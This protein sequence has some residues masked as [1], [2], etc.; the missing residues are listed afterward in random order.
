MSVDVPTERTARRRV[1]VVGNGGRESALRWAC[2]QFGHDVLPAGTDPFVA[3]PDL[4]I[5]GPEAPLADGLVD[6]LAAAGIPAFG[7]TAACARLEASKAYAREVMTALGLEGPRWHQVAQ[8]DVDGALAWFRASGFPIVVKLSGLA[9]GKGVIVPTDEVTTEAAIRG[10]VAQGDVVLEER[11][12]GPECSLLAFCDGTTARPMPIAQDHKRIGEGDTGPNTGGMGA[13]APAPLPY[14]ADL[15]T[16]QFIQP[17]LDHMRAAGTP[18]VGVLYAGLML[19]TDGPRLLEYNCRFGDPET[20]AILPLLHT[21]VVE[22]AE[23]CIAGRLAEID[24]RWSSGTACT[25]V[26]AAAGYPVDPRLGDEVFIG[27][28]D[29]ATVFLAGVSEIDGAA[30][31][32]GG[33]V[34][35]VTGTGSDLASARS[36]AYAGMAA[37]RFDGMQ[38]RRDIGWRAIASSLTTYAAAGVDIDE[39]NR[40]VSLLKESVKHTHNPSVLAGV[41]SFGGAIDISALKHYDRPVLVASTDGVGT[42]VELA[43]RAGRPEVSGMDIVNHCIDDVLVQG[44]RPLFFLDYIAAA[45]LDAELVA[46]VVDGMATACEASGCVLLG[47]ETAEM[48][49]VYTAGSFDVAGTLVGVVDHAQM[50]PRPGAVQPGDMLIGLGSSGPHT[51]GYSF[52]RKLFQWLPLDAQPAPLDRPLVD[53]LLQPHR[54]YITALDAALTDGRIKALAHITGGGLPENLPR[55]LPDGCGAV[56]QLDSWTLPP[57]FQLVRDVAWQTPTDELYRTLNM[58][59]GMVLIV[60][61][62]DVDRVRDSIPEQTWVIGEIVAGSGCSLV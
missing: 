21:D 34:L 15:L 57:L 40:A 59:I 42:K 9:A 35:S 14:D 47:G 48:P 24:I 17:I 8:G 13:Y 32:S 46:K 36:A 37:V 11:L 10:L 33:R 30:C 38:V 54:A 1:V 23:A 27:D 58:G 3:L 18:Y 39:G 5:V 29:S 28:M 31:V 56:V 43:A 22:I 16:A 19:T 7:P 20:Q 44:A 53:A 41:G 50:L 4:V 61:A 6:A 51:N 55:A 12:S 49:G 52:L 26:A 25:V 60:A 45:T 62:A 2:A